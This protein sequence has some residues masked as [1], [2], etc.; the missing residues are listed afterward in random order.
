MQFWFSPSSP[1]SLMGKSIMGL[2]AIAVAYGCQ[3]APPASENSTEHVLKGV[4]IHKEW[5]KSLESFNAGGSDYYV[6]KVQGSAIPS[7]RYSANEGVILRPS[8]TVPHER[9]AD[10]V[11]MEVICRGAFVDGQ[12]YAPVEDSAE[13]MPS[14]SLNPLTGEPEH[15]RV[16]AGFVVHT[17]E[18][19]ADKRSP[20]EQ[21]NA[22]DAR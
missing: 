21:T 7:G 16:G 12:P 18:P 4:V 9:L 15:P 10:F 19:V 13:Q 3:P 2:L 1:R 17:I 14:P 20:A 8:A 22:A 5:T 6:L 11:E